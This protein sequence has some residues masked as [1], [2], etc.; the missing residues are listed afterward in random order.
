MPLR[1]T[2]NTTERAWTEETLRNTY[3]P[4]N[5]G[6]SL[7]DISIAFGIPRTTLQDRRK[8]GKYCE[9][10]LG[11]KPVFSEGSE[12][13]LTYEV[14][15]LG[16]LFYGITLTEIKKCAFAYARKNNVKHSFN[17]IMEAAGKDWL[18]GF[19]MINRNFITNF[20]TYYYQPNTG[21]Q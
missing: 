15:K 18:K 20:Q 1:Y 16:K 10:S 6:R 12:N 7:R 4:I 3:F 2:R 11:P 5:N 17:S 14:V 13:E 8:V 9:A 19:L 21:F